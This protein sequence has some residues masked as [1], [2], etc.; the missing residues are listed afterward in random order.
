M[1]AYFDKF[2]NCYSGLVFVAINHLKNYQ[3][4]PNAKIL[5][6]LFRIVILALKHSFWLHLCT[7]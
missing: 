6:I 7:S 2:N 1:M 4:F 5:L 3:Y